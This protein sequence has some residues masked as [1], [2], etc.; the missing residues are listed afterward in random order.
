MAVSQALSPCTP[1]MC[2]DT[3]IA[4]ALH[5]LLFACWQCPL[6]ATGDLCQVHLLHETF[7]G[8]PSKADLC[9]PSFV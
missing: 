5:D 9:A 3:L 7:L 4:G 6:T 8:L 2:P 1:C